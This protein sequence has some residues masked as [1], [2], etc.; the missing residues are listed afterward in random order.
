[1]VFHKNIRSDEVGRIKGL[2]HEEVLKAA[3]L[4]RTGDIYP[5][6]TE[7]YTQMPVALGHPPFMVMGYVTPAGARSDNNPGDQWY[8]D[9]VKNK[10]NLHF[11]TDILFCSPHSGTHIDTLAHATVGE[12]DHWY[13]GCGAKDIGVNGVN[14]CS[15]ATLLPLFTRGLLLDV[16]KYKDVPV[17]PKGYGITKEDLAGTAEMEKVQL[18]QHDTVL[19]RTGLR[20]CYGDG[21]KMAAHAGSG[22]TKDAALYLADAGIVAAGSDT[23]CFE[24]F[25]GT[26]PDNPHIVHTIFLIEQGIHIMEILDLKALAADQKYEFLFVALPLTIRGSTASMINPIAVV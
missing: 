9:P 18:Q 24:Q 11:N 23:D 25:P 20:D 4:V 22:I 14:K 10:A 13:N 15:A 2:T 17:L 8:L 7:R 21:E 19:I 3:A 16:A 26:D 12:D 5:I 6:G 1:M